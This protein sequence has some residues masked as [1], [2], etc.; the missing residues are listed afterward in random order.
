MGL[1]RKRSASD[2]RSRGRSRSRPSRA[3]D[4]RRQHAR[5]ADDSPIVEID[6]GSFLAETA[7][8]YTVVDC[9]AAWCGPCLQFAPAFEELAHEYEGRIRFAK[10]NVDENPDVAAL[11]QI[12]SIPTIVV[13][14]PQGNE[15]TR[16]T[17][18]PHRREFVRVL[19]ELRQA[20]V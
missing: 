6:S 2:R 15:A 17:G 5:A 16:F 7:N 9:W 10:L 1:F 3:E 12:R 11:L 20:E 14:D 18:I 8:G 13:F 19:D 4:D